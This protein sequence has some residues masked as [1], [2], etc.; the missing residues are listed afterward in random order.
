MSDSSPTTAELDNTQLQ[1]A[2]DTAA[3]LIEA[4]KRQGADAAEVGVSLSQ[5]YSVN[6]RQGE[7]ETVEF[8]RD[9]GVS[10]TVYK[11]QRKGHAS[12]SDDNRDSLRAT[13]AAATAIAGYTEEDRY[14][15]L[16]PAADLAKEV[17]DLDL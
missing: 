7:V 15:G 14:A 3:W 4:A 13:L 6:V 8:H 9:R 10:V 2:K 17:T 5:G 12:S 11:G 16:A 1:Q